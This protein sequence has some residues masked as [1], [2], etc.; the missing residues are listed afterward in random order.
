MQH[1]AIFGATGEL[2]REVVHASLA[3]GHR[4]TVLCRDPRKLVFPK[5]SGAGRTGEQIKAD[6]RLRVIIG[7]VTDITDVNGVFATDARE[8]ITSCIVALGGHPTLSGKKRTMLAEGTRNIITALEAHK[9]KRIAVVTSMGTSDS[10]HQV[11]MAFW[12]IKTTILRT[13]FADKEVQE[14]LF[15]DDGAPGSRLEYV[16]IRPSSLTDTPPKGKVN[17]TTKRKGTNVARADVAAFCLDA[18]EQPAFPYLR[19]APC[20]DSQAD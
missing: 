4:V 12:L 7:N 2:G 20:L 8:Q 15:R 1:I 5:V 18:V 17:V 13:E 9:V 19:Q 14:R 6:E 3:R 10:K 11:P 16:I